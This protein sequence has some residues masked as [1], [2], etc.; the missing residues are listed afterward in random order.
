MKNHEIGACL[1]DAEINDEINMD[2]TLVVVDMQ[3]FFV[4]NCENK[5]LLE[6]AIA[7]VKLAMSKGW[8]VILLECKPWRLG[9]TLDEIL[10]VLEG[11]PRFV[12]KIKAKPDG[13]KEVIEVC[14]ENDYPDHNFRVVGVWVDACVEQTA[15]SLVERIAYCVVNVVKRACSTD[16]DEKGAWEAFRKR[17]RLVVA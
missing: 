13:A 14:R 7:E 16:W 17:N 8:A 1:S 12:Q 15:V 11:Y 4:K 3:W 6:N 5:Q 2:G 9:H 10:A